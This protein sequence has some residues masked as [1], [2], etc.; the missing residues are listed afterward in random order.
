MAYI[1]LD[2]L[3]L[4]NFFF[5]Y[6]VLVLTARM[7][8]SRAHPGRMAL[9]AL[10]G[11]G[12]FLLILWEGAGFLGGLAVKLL[13]S[14]LM[15]A[16]AFVPRL[17]GEFVRLLAYFYGVSFFVGGASFGLYSLARSGLWP[18]GP[19]PWWTVLPGSL[20][21]SIAGR[22]VLRRFSRRLWEERL[23]VPIWIGVGGK[24]VRLMSLVDTGNQLND[25]LTG[26][27]VIV[28]EL[29][30]LAVLLPPPVSEACSA[31]GET[32]GFTSF[33]EEIQDDQTGD[34][35]IRR[36]RLVPFRSLG[37]RSGILIGF[38]PDAIRIGE[39]PSGRA[40]VEAVV[41]VSPHALSQDGSYQ[42]LLHPEILSRSTYT[43][44]GSTLPLGGSA[45]AG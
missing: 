5:D 31:A 26:T 4:I 9:A 41:A 22:Y 33:L 38:R 32:E 37:T 36:I 1:Y 20:A 21:V 15:V 42:A 28:A 40:L 34:G 30:P 27:P 25:P 17:P 39:N 13:F 6:L 19:V 29:D 7:S 3:F 24:E 23:L 11:A 14:A 10:L 16:V 2:T 44:A 45:R 12:Y 35:W 43:G 18:L 8:G